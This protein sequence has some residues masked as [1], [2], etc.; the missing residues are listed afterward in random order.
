MILDLQIITIRYMLPSG[1]EATIITKIQ[2]YS[3][4]ILFNNLA[5]TCITFHQALNVA[6]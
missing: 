2:K 6:V 3:T 1:D 4:K 5:F